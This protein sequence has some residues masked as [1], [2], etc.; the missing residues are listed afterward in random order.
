V[1]NKV[2]KSRLK[3]YI[4]REIIKNEDCSIKDDEPLITGG[5]INSFSLVQIAVFIED[6]FK[7][8]IPDT[9]L[10]MENMDTLNDMTSRI[11][12]EMESK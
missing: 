8:K 10:T 6:E 2:I 1:E 11:E 4:L 12:L 5:L 7:V 3:H 9:D